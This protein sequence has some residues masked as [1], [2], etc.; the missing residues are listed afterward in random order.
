[1]KVQLQCDHPAAGGPVALHQPPACSSDEKE[2]A[3]LAHGV[4]SASSRASSTAVAHLLLS[5]HPPA[6]AHEQILHSSMAAFQ[7]VCKPSGAEEALPRLL[8]SQLTRRQPR[9]NATAAPAFFHEHCQHQVASTA[10]PRVLTRTHANKLGS[11]TQPCSPCY[12][13][14]ASVR[15]TGWR[16]SRPCCAA[17]PNHAC[18]PHP[19]LHSTPS[20]TFLHQHGQCQIH[21]LK[22]QQALL[23]H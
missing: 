11:N 7:T 14:M 2:T 1:M 9:G 4:S 18:A 5:Y 20:R 13:S 16:C 19:S 3:G 17:N 12:M 8:A 10:G 21:W 6:C 15:T 22:V 23:H